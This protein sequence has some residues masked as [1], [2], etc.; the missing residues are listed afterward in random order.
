MTFLGLF[1]SVSLEHE[2][3]D[4]TDFG[5]VFICD[6]EACIRF[7]VARFFFDRVGPE[8]VAFLDVVVELAVVDGL[9]G[10]NVFGAREV[11]GLE[12]ELTLGHY[13]A[14]FDRECTAYSPAEAVDEDHLDQFGVFGVEVVHL[15]G[16]QH[17]VE[18]V[19]E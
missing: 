13:F 12:A 8:P 9:V 15:E 6:Q 14:V 3:H 10:S 16:A 5:R 7:L 17:A 11:V 1:A 18:Q 19:D 2:I 4:L